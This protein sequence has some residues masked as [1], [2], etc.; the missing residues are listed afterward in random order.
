MAC[1]R[2]AEML[3]PPSG[4]V[5]CAAVTWCQVAPLLL[6]AAAAPRKVMLKNCDELLSEPYGLRWRQSRAPRAGKRGVCAGKRAGV[7]VLWERARTR[8]NTIAYVHAGTQRQGD[9]P[10]PQGVCSA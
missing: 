8:T 3:A 9:S 6:L 7:R 10:G 4:T 2:R 1:P 5:R